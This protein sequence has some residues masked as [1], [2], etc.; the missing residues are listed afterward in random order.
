MTHI[1]IS[2]KHEESSSDFISALEGKL[3]NQG[4]DVWTDKE[5]Q[6]GKNWRAA[7]DEAVR[8]S[9]A[10]IVVLTPGANQS[11]YVT[12]EW[13]YAMGL[14]KSVVPIKLEE[15]DFH[16][17]L[18]VLQFVNFSI[19]FKEPWDDLIQLLEKYRA[20]QDESPNSKTGIP[21]QQV[22]SS[23]IVEQASAFLESE[24]VD[25]RRG[26]NQTVINYSDRRS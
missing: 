3:E 4:I 15:T 26:G 16:P 24:N 7:I 14:G 12:Y 22:T 17:K 23:S 1:F 25:Q 5:I 13:S 9:Y 2:Y 18:S 19:R 6:G 20:G 10:V 11:P 8:N 21:G